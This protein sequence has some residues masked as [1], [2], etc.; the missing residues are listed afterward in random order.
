MTDR[1]GHWIATGALLLATAAPAL[2]A[3]P[4]QKCQASKLKVAGKYNA[5]RL[6]AESKAV[7]TG[8]PVDYAKCDAKYVAKWI[9]VETNG[10]GMCPTEGDQNVL[11]SQIAADSGYIA[12][13][14]AGVRF[15]DNGNGTV[16]DLLTKLTWEKKTDDSSVH[17][18]DNVYTWSATIPTPNGTLF[19]SFLG[20]LNGNTS[21]DGGAVSGCFAGHCDWRVPTTAEIETILL[22]PALCATN[23]CIAPVFGSVPLTAGYLTSTTLADDP[24][25]VWFMYTYDGFKGLS[26]KDDP[27]WAIAV[28]GGS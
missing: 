10:G 28:R 11:Q 27:G 17:D 25:A 2:A 20:T 1:W 26:F 14:L 15:I 18:G 13:R 22:E 12:L 3:S 21:S 8:N 7:A 6:N 23:P 16:T 9:T 5:C 24:T 4:A 19:T